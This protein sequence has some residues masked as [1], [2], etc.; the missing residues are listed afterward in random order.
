MALTNGQRK[1]DFEWLAPQPVQTNR[2]WRVFTA[3][4]GNTRYFSN[5]TGQHLTGVAPA[6]IHCSR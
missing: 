2:L 3:Y 1:F 6:P 5:G 4:K